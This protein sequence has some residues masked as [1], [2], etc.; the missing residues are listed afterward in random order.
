VLD[1]AVPAER[2]S[3][4]RLSVNILLT[5]LGSLLAGAFLTFL[6]ESVKNARPRSGPV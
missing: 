1:R 6:V 3:R 5:G 2:H 4:P